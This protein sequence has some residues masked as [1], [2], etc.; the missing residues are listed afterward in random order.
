MAETSACVVV[1]SSCS[2]R[3]RFEGGGTVV[4]IVCGVTWE[5]LGGTENLRSRGGGI[6][7][8]EEAHTQH[9]DVI[10]VGLTK[11]VIYNLIAFSANSNFFFTPRLLDRVQ[12]SRS[13]TSSIAGIIPAPNV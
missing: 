3:W 2:R 10:K 11:M 7:S 5:D 6:M 13:C 9:T 4:D 8:E 12:L 1:R